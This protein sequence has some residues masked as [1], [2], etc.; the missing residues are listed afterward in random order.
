MITIKTV[1]FPASLDKT[2]FQALKLSITLSGSL[3]D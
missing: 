2:K 1:F 3:V